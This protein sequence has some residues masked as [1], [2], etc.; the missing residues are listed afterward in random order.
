V[1]IRDTVK[2]RRSALGTLEYGRAVCTGYASLTAALLR[3]S[4]I[5]AQY[6]LGGVSFSD[7]GHAWLEAYV[8]NKWII[9][10]PTWGSGNKWEKGEKTASPG[11][12]SYENFEM[13]MDDFS[14]KHRI[15]S[16]QN[17]Y[18]PFIGTLVENGKLIYCGEN[19]ENLKGMGITSLSGGVFRGN[20]LMK[21][22]VIPNGV[23]IIPPLCLLLTKI[24]KEWS[25]PALF[26]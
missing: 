26:A 14:K 6:V 22:L 15:D 18:Y 2:Y 16:N 8:G 17:G 3:A 12:T 7:M 11:L 13:S 1:S 4:G 23:S 10:D 19:G 25:C 21:N 20:A 9:M 24:L 5:P